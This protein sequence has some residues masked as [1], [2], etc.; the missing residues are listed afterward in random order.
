MRGTVVFVTLK[1]FDFRIL[2][3]KVF[4]TLVFYFYLYFNIFRNQSIS[5]ILQKYFDIKRSL[6]VC[7]KSDL[8][9]NNKRRSVFSG[10]TF[11]RLF[12]PYKF[13]NN[14]HYATR[15]SDSNLTE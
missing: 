9:L 2:Q 15:K 14:T 5:W 8:Y 13:V 3:F 12:Y 4:N 10:P 6:S 11:F 7:T 1:Y